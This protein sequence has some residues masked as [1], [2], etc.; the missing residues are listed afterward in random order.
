M[1]PESEAL[2]RILAAVAPLPEESLAVERATGRFAARDVRSTAAL[3]RFDQSAMDGYALRAAD[4]PGNLRIVGEQPAGASR[5][6]R[7]G[8]G[9][10]ARIFTGAP[11]PDGADAV[12]MQ[13]DVST[14]DGH[15]RVPERV[16]SGEFIRR[17][18]EEVCAGQLLLAA[19]RRVTAPAVGLLCAAGVEALSVHR[20]PRLAIVTTGDEV[21]PPGAPLATGELYDSNGPML[22]AQLAP[23]A[24]I[25]L[26]THCGDEEATLAET[27][28]S[29]TGAD[30]IVLSAGVSVGDHDPVHG[31]LRI[32]GA[33]VDIWRVA[34]K[35]GKPFLLA[36]HGEQVVFG[37]PG[38]P[39]SSFV[40]AHLFVRPA[41]ARM[42]GAS[43][44]V[45][46]S[47][48]IPAGIA[49][50]NPGDRVLYVRA[51]L[52][53]GCAFPAPLQHSRG[54][55]SLAESDLLLR[56][57]PGADHAPGEITAALPLNFEVDPSL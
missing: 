1:I 31:A 38:N 32:L 6:L 37:L 16:Q 49:I 53:D 51:M 13:E 25:A 20:R 7:I 17:R 28:R 8:R 55:V 9:E 26:V 12:V 5:G 21:R 43:A 36:R 3:P 54:L 2:E 33:C 42:A 22:A 57:E 50:R 34:V 40:T 15:V 47:I 10:A 39:V 56:L 23:A 41:L 52:R 24:D 11:L 4:A 14:T 19:G 46:F 29:C 35:P 18:G 44:V 27:L 30:A 45:P 48:P